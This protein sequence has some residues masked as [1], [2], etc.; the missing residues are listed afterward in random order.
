MT[1][2]PGHEYEWCRSE[3]V[4]GALEGG[5]PG[6]TRRGVGAVKAAGELEGTRDALIEAV[7]LRMA[8]GGEDPLAL[9]R[10]LVAAVRPKSPADTGEAARSWRAM[11]ALLE[12][13]QEYRQAAAETVLALFAGRQ[14]RTLYTEAGVLPNTGFFSEL[15]RSLTH[16]FLPELVDEDDLRDCV[17]IIFPRPSTWL[18]T[19][20]L[21]DRTAFWKLL[22]SVPDV[23]LEAHATIREQMLDAAVVLGH[24]T[25]S[26]GL[27]PELL[28]VLP[29]LA[30]GES[31]FIAL[32]DQLGLFVRSFRSPGAAAQGTGEEDE[33]H[34]LVLVDQCRDAVARARQAAATRGT[35]M[36]LTFLLVR[37]GQHLERLEL[38]VRVLAAR[39]NAEA[40]AELAERW[41]SFLRHAIESELER[42]SI[43]R[44]VADLTGILSLRVTENAGHTGEHYIAVD[45]ADWARMWG[46]AAV[47]G[48]FIA[49][50]ALLKIRGASL[51][52]AV[53]NEGLLN[54][55]I[56]GI[57]FAVIHV[58]HGTVATKQPAMTAATLAS[59]LGRIRS[60]SRE[61][62]EVA[63]LVAAT[64][65]TQSAAIAGNLLVAFPL[66]LAV[67]VA[68]RS[69]SGHSI[70]EAKAAKLLA[71]IDL[72]AL[73][74]LLY[75]AVAGIWL[76][77]AGIVSGYVD[78]LVAYGRLSE[79][80]AAHPGLRRVLGAERS[81]KVG[82]YLGRNAGGLSGNLFFGVMLGITPVLGIV[83]GLPLDIRHIA[84]SAANFG[85]ALTAPDFHV[86]AWVVLRCLAGIL[87]IGTVNLIVS[88]FLALW[89]ALRAHQA[90]LASLR[91]LLPALVRQLR[92]KPSR[93]FFPGRQEEG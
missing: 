18:R 67:G 22:S 13:N 62:E 1:V 16:K 88:F 82:D 92:E 7:L 76:F 50:L 61:I 79:R 26:M 39:F 72:L 15:R 74:P 2:H 60:R 56:Y 34:V 37:L 41:G 64:V 85:Y 53:L 4:N 6:H 44:H 17:A 45:R 47:G 46:A 73:A 58:F 23:A 35:S 9:V 14:Q 24:R 51:H 70:P 68:L 3:S 12:A 69:G 86:A 65:R 80:V 93:F 78:N 89:L 84:F 25:A 32:S 20:P 83:S 87:A 59:A 42:N 11:L 48:F 43:R 90:S 27:E 8:S 30:R 66:A 19:V 91:G 36:A 40:R 5:V 54:G 75:A 81:Q 28:R 31:P 49:L 21:A 77:A 57:G 10:D 55:A 29:R 63:D 71:D 52:L 38:L 33:R